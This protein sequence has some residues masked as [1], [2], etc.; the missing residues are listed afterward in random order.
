MPNHSLAGVR[1]VNGRRGVDLA[2]V[3]RCL[4]ELS[5]A[6][7]RAD[8][9]DAAAS[10]AIDLT[11]A[12]TAAVGSPVADPT[13][14]RWAGPAP[15]VSVRRLVDLAEEAVLTGG[16]AGVRVRQA[17]LTAVAVE[18]GGRPAGVLV[19]ALPS[20]GAQA[21]A[22]LELLR[23]V[24]AHTGRCLE[25]LERVRPAAEE[26]APAPDE[27]GADQ[28]ELVRSLSAALVRARTEQEVGQVVAR[29]LRRVIDHRSCR[30]YIP[31]ADGSTLLAIVHHGL[32]DPAADDL[33]VRPREGLVARVFA[34]AE[35]ERV[36]D[37]AGSGR[38]A[39]GPVADRG[40]D[41]RG[42]RAAGRRGAGQG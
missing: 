39:L 35:A 10:A 5:A 18:R 21:A 9:F 28:L 32:G 4:G 36:D 42:E 29:E 37:A 33:D 27:R 25:A 26:P 8:L 31:S 17:Q 14:W 12:A 19:A 41:G 3:A 6:R 40:A 11:G 2:N 22:R 20:G 1:D 13:V 15:S 30:F 16:T 7:T 24:A 38:R 34:S 23:M